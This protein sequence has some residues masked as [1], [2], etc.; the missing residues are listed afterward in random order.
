[1]RIPLKF[2]GAILCVFI[3]SLSGAGCGAVPKVFP[4]APAQTP[5][6]TQSLCPDG[7]PSTTIAAIQGRQHRSPLEGKSV[8][9]VFG[10]VTAVRADGFYLQ[11]PLGDGDD[12]TSEGLFV[13]G[14]NVRQL[15]KGDAVV[16]IGGL[17]REVNP[18]GPGENSLT[19][20]TLQSQ[21]LKVLSSENALPDA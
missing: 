19:T 13:T 6:A 3:F 10:I 7:Q 1:M 9:C 12:A 5:T 14:V 18:A 11:D 17:V 16:A 20:T 2:I 8:A 4:T 21:E 15:K